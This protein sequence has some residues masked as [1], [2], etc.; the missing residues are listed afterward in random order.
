MSDLN[1]IEFVPE[2]EPE[3]E[4]ILPGEEEVVEEEGDPEF[5]ELS[6]DDVIKRL[7]EEQEARKSLEGKVDSVSAITSGLEKL[8]QNLTRPV[9][10]QPAPQQQQQVELSEEEKA[11][12]YNE[13]L[14]DGDVY[15]KTVN[16]VNDQLK[17]LRPD[18]E[19]I[20][21][22]NLVHS[23]KFALLN[24]DVADVMKLHGPEVEAEVAALPP[25]ER[26]KDPDV[27]EKAAQRVGVRY[28]DEI[29]ERKVQEVL[30]AKGIEN[31]TGS[32]S[33]TVST[34]VPFTETNQRPNP[35]KRV[36]RPTK[37]QIE[38]ARVLGMTIEKY[39]GLEV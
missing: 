32:V 12:L 24:P 39:M 38:E 6:K 16:L 29:V 35:K 21:Q 4:I 15:S 25:A 17:K 22:A 14:L 33:P 18:L 2:E 1:N 28:V 37:E 31:T 36:V 5:K 13:G 26:I 27:Y 23:K 11:R 19:A 20:M 30:K 9:V 34:T 10:Q 8:N 7:R 3:L